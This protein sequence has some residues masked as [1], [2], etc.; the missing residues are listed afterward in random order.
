[1]KLICN[2]EKAAFIKTAVWKQF[3]EYLLNKRGRKCESCGKKEY[4]TVH[5][6]QKKKGIKPIKTVLQIHQSVTPGKTRGLNCEPL[7]AVCYV[8]PKG[9]WL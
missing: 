6:S 9:G 1:M 3:R 8:P 2:K 4:S 5:P 7:K